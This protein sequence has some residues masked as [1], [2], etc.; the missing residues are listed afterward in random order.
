M[1]DWFKLRSSEFWRQLIAISLGLLAGAKAITS[2]QSG[3]H[4]WQ[5]MALAVL[6]VVT[7]GASK[8]AWKDE[9]R[10]AP[11]LSKPPVELVVHNIGWLSEQGHVV[12][13]T[14]DM[15]W[16][17]DPDLEELLLKKADA[18]DLTIVAGKPTKRLSELKQR[19][20]MVKIRHDLP[21]V[22]FTALRFGTTD[23]RVLVHQQVKGRVQFREYAQGDF[24]V[25]WLCLD[26]IAAYTH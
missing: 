8:F 13:V 21:K 12:V 26:L 16:A 11:L 1:L 19:G 20:A 3:L 17:S 25:Y 7:I 23:C 5:I 4:V 14:R 2:F 15:S 10:R 9:R 18:G 22:R 6:V 24:P